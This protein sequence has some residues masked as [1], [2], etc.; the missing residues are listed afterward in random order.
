MSQRKQR[1]VAASMIGE[2]SLLGGNGVKLNKGK[3][4]MEKQINTQIN[5]FF[6]YQ[7]KI[8]GIKGNEGR[9]LKD[10]KKTYE[11]TSKQREEQL[12]FGP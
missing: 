5:I 11:K 4:I 6:L 2:T 1:L 12:T 9:F 7:K 8:V 3:K 10:I